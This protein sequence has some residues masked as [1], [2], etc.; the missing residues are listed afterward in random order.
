MDKRSNLR[1][2]TDM[3]QK[4]MYTLEELYDNLKISLSKLSKIA[5][6]NEGTLIRIRKGQYSARKTTVNKLLDAFSEVYGIE[7]SLD[8]VTGIQ[9]EDKRAQQSQKPIA[10]TVEKPSIP[11][12][13]VPTTRAVAEKPQRRTYKP[14]DTGIPEGAILAKHF[15]ENHNV[16]W[17]TFYDHLT[18]GL[19]PGLIPG[20]DVPTDGSVLIRDIVKH[21]SPDN[22]KRKG[23]KIRY[24]TSDQQAAALD[25]W[26][27]WNVN[28]SECD[29]PGCACHKGDE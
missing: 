27:K 21:E 29:Q 2:W 8:N 3:K 7:L 24:L 11:S 18:K 9:V 5:D 1:E 22:P 20:P 15:A 14:R 25:F 10:Q 23:E 4:D 19:G 17:G 16:S 6:I 26:E 28:Y 12:P 13:V